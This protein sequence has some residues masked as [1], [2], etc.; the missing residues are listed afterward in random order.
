[1]NGEFKI[2]HDSLEKVFKSELASIKTINDERYN[3]RCEE[4]KDTKHKINRIF[5]EVSNINQRC[6]DRTAVMTKF[7][8][9]INQ[10]I[11]DKDKKYNFWS[12]IKARTLILIFTPI[13]IALGTTFILAI[14]FTVKAIL[15]SYGIL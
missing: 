13:M 15:K 6:F 11:K 1:M 4:E 3:S 10:D 2:L 14:R 5:E 8:Q 7:E 12:D 9:H